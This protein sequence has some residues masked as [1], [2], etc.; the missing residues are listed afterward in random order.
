MDPVVI[1]VK[2]VDIEPNDCLLEQELKIKLTIEASREIPGAQ[3]TVN[4]LV[5][6]VHARKIIHLG[7]LPQ[8]R[9]PAGESVVEFFTPTINVEGIPSEVLTNVGLLTMT[10]EAEK[11]GK[12]EHIVDINMGYVLYYFCRMRRESVR[13]SHK[14]RKNSIQTSGA[15]QSKRA[16]TRS[17]NGLAAGPFK[18]DTERN[19]E[20]IRTNMGLVKIIQ[21]SLAFSNKNGVVAGHPED[22]RAS[23]GSQRPPPSCV[24]KINFHFDVREDMYCA[25]ALEQLRAPIGQG[26][27][28]IDL[29]ANLRRG[30][31][32]D[33]FSE[34]ITGSGL[35]MSPDVTWITVGGG[36]LFAGLVR[37]LSG[38]ALP[39]TEE[40]FSETCYEY[41]P[42][43][44][45]MRVFRRCS[46]RC[47]MPPRVPLHACSSER[48]ILAACG[49]D[50]ETSPTLALT[51]AFFRSGW[52][53]GGMKGS[54]DDS[55]VSSSVL[56]SDSDA[57]DVATGRR[58]ASVGRW[59]ADRQ[60]RRP[61]QFGL[62]ELSALNMESSAQTW[63]GKGVDV[64]SRRVKLRSAIEAEYEQAESSS[65]G[66]GSPASRQGSL[67]VEEKQQ[68]NGVVPPPP[69][70][71]P[72]GPPPPL[73]AHSTSGSNTSPSD[74]Q[75]E[76]PRHKHPL[77]H[78]KYPNGA[79][80]PMCGAI[81]YKGPPIAAR[82][83][84][85][86][87]MKR[88]Q[89]FMHWG[90]VQLPEVASSHYRRHSQNPVEIQ[91]GGGG[92]GENAGTRGRHRGAR[93]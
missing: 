37:M 85:G 69:P 20:I 83:F 66:G 29:N 59:R 53:S 21:L 24:W 44:W 72:P 93:G 2:S 65:I 48:S 10:L 31:S 15:M 26:G 28:G 38:Q 63:R 36:F 12:K 19:Y 56:R 79:P 89:P 9:V 30:V 68:P 34:L 88:G 64:I 7:G 1:D 47:G 71:P 35:V 39:K 76:V 51:D 61:S 60:A 92:G 75:E 81:S 23:H 54:S 18:D 57:V 13:S 42:H 67:P 33:R 52:G 78:P 49:S 58:R 22:V 6:T 4:Y 40:E 14:T 41:F 45:D 73:D 5:D 90:C 43:I 32:V 55:S 87:S 77:R 82:K 84:A 27:A 17:A 25:D 3:W 62:W 50:L 8:G 11:E 80:P 46:A 74:R 86:S 91:A 16:S 70:P